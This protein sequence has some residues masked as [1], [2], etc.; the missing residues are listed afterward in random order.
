MIILKVIVNLTLALIWAPFFVLY[1]V[2]KSTFQDDK[3][4]WE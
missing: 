1:V 2:P 4:I 3:F